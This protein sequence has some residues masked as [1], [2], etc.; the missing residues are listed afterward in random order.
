MK[1]SFDAKK[2]FA[3]DGTPGEIIIVGVRN[4]TSTIIRTMLSHKKV[5]VTICDVGSEE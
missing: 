4:D 5:R 1:I 2:V 3:N